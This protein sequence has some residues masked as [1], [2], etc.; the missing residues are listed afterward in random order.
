VHL[1]DGRR[2][3]RGTVVALV[4]QVFVEGLEVMGSSRR[5][6]I[7]PSAGTMWFSTFRR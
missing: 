6:A 7:G 3:E 1:I 2:R 4:E 5:D